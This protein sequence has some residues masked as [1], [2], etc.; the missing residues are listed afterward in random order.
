MFFGLFAGFFDITI[1]KIIC[2]GVEWSAGL[3]HNFA[4]VNSHKIDR[5][6]RP[7]FLRGLRE[8]VRE[9]GFAGQAV[10]S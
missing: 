7:P 4:G 2:Q 6:A 8:P 5:P 3:Y 1:D 9:R 10:R